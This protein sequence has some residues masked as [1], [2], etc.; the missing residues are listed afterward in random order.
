M[1]GASAVP[2]SV[3]SV[4]RRSTGTAISALAQGPGRTVSASAATRSA[5]TGVIAEEQLDARL[6]EILAK[7]AHEGRGGLTD[8]ENRILQEASRRA[9]DRRGVR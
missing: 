2:G 1:A 9:R 6:D 7:I 5:P 8:D 3:S 4:R